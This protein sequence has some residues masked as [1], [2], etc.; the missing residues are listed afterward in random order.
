M[1]C[2]FRVARR[3]AN[4]PSP[5]LAS[6]ELYLRIGA[7]LEI[8]FGLDN[9]PLAEEAHSLAANMVITLVSEDAINNVKYNLL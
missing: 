3:R 4:L 2:S 8:I 6:P 7:A 5:D 9:S 1:A